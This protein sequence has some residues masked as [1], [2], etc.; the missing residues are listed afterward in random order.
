MLVST[1]RSSGQVDVWQ[2]F[3]GASGD[4]SFE[5]EQL[6]SQ[7]VYSLSFDPTVAEVGGVLGNC[8]SGR[9]CI[10]FGSVGVPAGVSSTHY[11]SMVEFVPNPDPYAGASVGPAYLPP[12]ITATGYRLPV[13]ISVD[14]SDPAVPF[15]L[16]IDRGTTRWDEINRVLNTTPQTNFGWP[17]REGIDE[18]QAAARPGC[19]GRNW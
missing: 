18:V 5:P 16:I 19:S 11:G 12:V 17:W 14:Q 2:V 7:P 4:F 1:R 3:G 10:A 6:G 8:I 13:A 9:A 15:G